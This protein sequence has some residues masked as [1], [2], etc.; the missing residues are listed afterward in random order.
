MVVQRLG[1]QASTAEGSALT[2]GWGT[3][4]PQARIP[5]VLFTSSYLTFPTLIGFKSSLKALLSTYYVPDIIP[6][7]SGHIIKQNR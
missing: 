6:D 3:K 4:I 1:L 7:P 5:K 2:S